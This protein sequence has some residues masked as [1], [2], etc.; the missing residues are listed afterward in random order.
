MSEQN[1]EHGKGPSEG[2]TRDIK[3]T[4]GILT[5]LANLPADAL[6]DEAAMGRAFA[7]SCRTIRRM[8]DRYELPPP[9]RIAGKSVWIAGRVRAYINDAAERKEKKAKRAH[10][11]IRQLGP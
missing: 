7:V 5:M 6:V 8:V 11:R 1:A 10:I 9:I 4:A 2:N 3:E